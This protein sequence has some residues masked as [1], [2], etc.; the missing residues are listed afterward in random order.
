MSEK[1][2]STKDLARVLTRFDLFVICVSQILGAG[3]LSMTGT[4][5][6]MTGRSVILSFAVAAFFTIMQALPLVVIAGVIRM[7]GG[8]YTQIA[9]LVQKMWAGVYIVCF[10]F[11]NMSL[12]VYGLSFA[13]YFLPIV[14]GLPKKVV[15]IGI[16]TII[17]VVQYFGVKTSVTI[18]KVLNMVLLASFIMFAGFG[19]M[20]LQPGYFSE[21][22]FMTHGTM[23][24]LQAAATLSFATGGAT[25]VLNY[26]AEAK[27]P[28]KDI[29]FVIILST[30]VIACLYGAMAMAAAG[31]LPLEQVSGQS[32]LKVAQKV[33]PGP[34]YLFFMIGCWSNL[35]KT[36]LTQTGG[37]TKPLLQATVDGWFPKGIAKLN[38]Y[39]VPIILLGI[40]Y[41]IG[42]TPIL[43]GFNISIVSNMVLFIGRG[44]SVVASISIIFIPKVIPEAWGRS[45]MKMSNGMLV[46][47]GLASSAVL[48]FQTY[49]SARNLPMY[50]VVANI[51]IFTGSLAFGALRQKSVNMEI[52]YEEA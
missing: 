37:M 34:L 43:I 39:K 38:S 25:S 52:S 49:L 33:L 28:V 42:V 47:L 40:F 4:G 5:I 24:I 6:A 3:I 51:I 13:D 45:K 7:R 17:F 16:I 23:G 35:S 46:F 41:V 29:P 31:V 19:L 36:L 32:L 15:A 48:A 1:T 9:L 20:N 11:Q 27:N 26:S 30:L 22:G 2:V 50:L 18:M 14:P 21:P 10:I 8:I 44:F 12:A